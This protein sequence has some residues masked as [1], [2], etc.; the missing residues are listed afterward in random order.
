MP[1]FGFVKSIWVGS[2]NRFVVQKNVF[3]L[4]KKSYINLL[5]FKEQHDLKGEGIRDI[6]LSNQC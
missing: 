2:F 5:K 4:G 3:D 1:D 6:N